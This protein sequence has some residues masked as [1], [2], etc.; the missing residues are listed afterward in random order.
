MDWSNILSGVLSALVS[1]GIA[2]AVSRS[3][4]RTELARRNIDRVDERQFSDLDTLSGEVRG[5]RNSCFEDVLKSGTLSQELL[6]ALEVGDWNGY[7]LNVNPLVALIDRVATLGMALDSEQLTAR[8]REIEELVDR[9]GPD[10]Y[11]QTLQYAVAAS[12]D[13]LT[14]QLRQMKADR[15]RLEARV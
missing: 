8:A 12:L 2:W 15:M 11:D 9:A 6:L 10:C 3:S 5:C 4:T 13:Q 1:A 7:R 14:L